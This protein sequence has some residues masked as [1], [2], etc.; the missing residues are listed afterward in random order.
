MASLSLFFIFS[1]KKQFN[2][3]NVNF[4]TPPKSTMILHVIKN[5]KYMKEKELIKTIINVES[6]MKLKFRDIYD[7]TRRGGNQDDE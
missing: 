3:D 5:I 2:G 6:I 4:P 1:N 7:K